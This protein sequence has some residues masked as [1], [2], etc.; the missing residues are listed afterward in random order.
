MIRIDVPATSANLCVGFDTLGIAFN[1][2]NSFTFEKNFMDDVSS[3]AK[4][5]QDNNMVL[6]AYRSFFDEYNLKYIPVK[7]KL[8]NQEIPSERG[9]GSSATCI[10][11]GVMA[12]NIISKSNFS[13]ADLLEICAKIEGHPD[14]VLPALI[15]GLCAAIKGDDKHYFVK[16]NISKKLNFYSLIPDFALKTSVSRAVLPSSYSRSDVVHNLSRIVN[17]PYAF[18]NGDMELIKAVM[19]DKIH[20]P[21]RL[22]LIKNAKAV[23]DHFKNGTVCIS[24]AGSCLLLITDCDIKENKIYDF[25]IKKVEVDL[26]GVRAYEI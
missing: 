5:Y 9:L 4:E 12:A 6:E 14:N 8:I 19:N 23:K 7:I 18:E 26:E 21:Y 25:E 17:L 3:F 10:V 11:A 15:G 20:E 2:Y 16:Y 22:E 1:L 24:G 13:K